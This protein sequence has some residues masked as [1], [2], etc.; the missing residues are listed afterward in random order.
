MGYNS[1][2]RPY[3]KRTIFISGDI[4]LENIKRN[5]EEEFIMQIERDTLKTQYALKNKI[6]LMTI[7]HNVEMGDYIKNVQFINYLRS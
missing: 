4:K 3:N 1:K 5:M 7:P 2:R 6:N